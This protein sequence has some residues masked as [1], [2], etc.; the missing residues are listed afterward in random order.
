MRLWHAEQNCFLNLLGVESEGGEGG[1]RSLQPR[2]SRQCRAPISLSQSRHFGHYTV[3]PFIWEGDEDEVA[4]GTP[5]W[6]SSTGSQGLGEDTAL[7]TSGPAAFSK[8]RA[9]FFGE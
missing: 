5:P 1:P 8:H 3:I 9:T 7:P 2:V 4:P 6:T